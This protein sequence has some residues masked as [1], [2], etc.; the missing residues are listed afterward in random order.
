MS[1]KN[2]HGEGGAKR[3]RRRKL[4]V[5]DNKPPAG[6][7]P[8]TLVVPE[9]SPAPRIRALRYT[10]SELEE[11]E[12]HSERE[13]RDLCARGGK[14]WVDVQGLGDR[15]TLEWIG[16]SFALHPLVLS[17]VVHVPQRPKS[18]AY[19][20]TAFTVARHLSWKGDPQDLVDE[21]QVSLVIAKDHVLSFQER[22]DELFEP[23]RARLLRG[24]GSI[25]RMG[26]DSLAYALLD[27][28]VDGYMPILD[29]IGERLEVLEERVITS[30]ERALMIEL[31]ALRRD[32]VAFRRDV[33][34][35]REALYSLLRGEA[36]EFS[37][38][39]K[40]YLRDVHD[41]CMQ[42]AEMVEVYREIAASIQNLY[43][44]SL[45]NRTNEVMKV[46]TV[47]STIFIPLT[48]LVG[49]WGMNFD[50]MPELRWP[51]AYPLVWLAMLTLA[52]T[53]FVYFR[54]RGWI[55]REPD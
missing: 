22:E 49:V 25:R 39:V 55:G 18:E 24:A 42:V 8:G 51:W 47:M 13:L 33:W 54:R 9:G 6:S 46:L 11:R 29:K 2:E 31:S 15:D 20:T 45:A 35:Q 43:L 1:R 5:A 30:P 50:F 34:P 52:T 26:T 21:R 53:L 14:L 36:G 37:D 16:A 23:V 10:E 12:I 38:A 7:H 27:A 3:K 41:H 4:R 28:I 44:T 40:L 32:L 19:E 17:D 48:F